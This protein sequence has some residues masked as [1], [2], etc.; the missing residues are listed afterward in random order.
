M[1]GMLV[2]G[3]GPRELPFVGCLFFFMVSKSGALTGPLTVADVIFV[4]LDGAWNT[5]RRAA[6]CCLGGFATG[7]AETYAGVVGSADNSAGGGCGLGS[8][9][10]DLNMLNNE[11]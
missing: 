1:K 9:G 6:L 2:V 11:S 5:L 3:D 4:L 7:C 10:V 8:G